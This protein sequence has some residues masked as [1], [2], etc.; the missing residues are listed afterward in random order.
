M[1]TPTTTYDAFLGQYDDEAQCF[2]RHRRLGEFSTMEAL[3]EAYEQERTEISPH[4]IVAKTGET[5]ENDHDC[6]VCGSNGFYEVF[7]ITE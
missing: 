7:V 5:H 2:L 4:M 6:H 1:E 3:R